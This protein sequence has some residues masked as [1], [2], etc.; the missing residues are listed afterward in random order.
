MTRR[1]ASAAIQDTDASRVDRGNG[2]RGPGCFNLGDANSDHPLLFD[3]PGANFPTLCD[4]LRTTT[5]HSCPPCSRQHGPPGRTS[6]PAGPTAVATGGVRQRR[7]EPVEQQRRDFSPRRGLH[8][9]AQ[10]RAKRRQPRSAALGHHDHQNEALKGR[11]NGLH[12]CISETRPSGSVAP[13]PGGLC[14]HRQSTP[15]RSCL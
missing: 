8:T 5:T 13:N 11:H 10:G 9:P 7:T 2:Q 3:R 14:A 6:A 12:E 1:R 4:L 15:S